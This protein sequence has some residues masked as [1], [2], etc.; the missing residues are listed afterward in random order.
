[1]DFD[2][3]YYTYGDEFEEQEVLEERT[4]EVQE[5][6]L[7]LI[8]VFEE[9]RT[10]YGDKVFKLLAVWESLVIGYAINDEENDLGFSDLFNTSKQAIIELIGEHTYSKIEKTILPETRSKNLV[11][12]YLELTGI[13]KHFGHPCLKVKDGFENVREHGTKKAVVDQVLVETCKGIFVRDFIKEYYHKKRKWPALLK[14]SKELELYYTKNLY[15]PKKHEKDYSI[16]SN[17]HLSKIFDFD[18]SPDT[19]ELIKDTASAPEFDQWFLPYD[20]CAFKHLYN[21]PKPIYKGVYK[22]TRVIERFLIGTENEVLKKVNKLDKKFLDKKDSTAVLCRKEQK[23]KMEGKLFVK[24]TYEQ[25]L[26]QT[27]MENII[28]KQVMK[29]VPEQTMTDGEL[30][31][32]RRLVDAA[33]SQGDNLEIMN[34]NLSKWNMRFRHALVFPFGKIIDQMFGLKN[35]YSYNHVWFIKSK[36]FNNS[37]LYP[38]DYDSNFEPI[39]GDYFYENHLGRMEGMRQK[40]WTLIT[41]CIIKLSAKELDLAIDIM[42][43]GDNQVVI[44][45]Y[46]PRQLSIKVGNTR[47]S[48]VVMNSPSAALIR[49]SVFFVA[50]VC[51]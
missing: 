11:K 4:E 23:L 21:K 22:P 48:S 29:Y 42:C 19:T 9:L 30:Q 8:K 47:H 37:R 51:V 27:A 46:K 34:L 45:R 50:L 32:T 38:S 13:C 40:L 3:N 44:I 20:N 5:H 28:A 39:S 2:F 33:K 1:M 43:Q 26:A 10:N 49:K 24:Q 41:I 7:E 6:G 17:I 35:L 14:Y 36:V 15:P 18:Y 31:Q 12:L 16:W 25:R